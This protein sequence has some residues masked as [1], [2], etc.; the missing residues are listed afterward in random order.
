VSRQRARELAV[1][2]AVSLAIMAGLAAWA[3]WY[4]DLIRL[5]VLAVR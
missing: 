4:P 2:A 1:S 3:W 5:L